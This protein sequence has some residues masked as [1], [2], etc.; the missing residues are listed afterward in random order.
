MRGQH[1][2][3][4]QEISVGKPMQVELQEYEPSGRTMVSR[5]SD[6]SGKVSAEKHYYT[7]GIQR[8][9]FP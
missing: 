3:I 4:G 2:E 8:S 6:I 1:K 5:V 9:N 7:R